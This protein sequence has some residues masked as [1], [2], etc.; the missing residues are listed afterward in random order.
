[1]EDKEIFP[2]WGDLDNGEESYWSADWIIDPDQDK[3]KVVLTMTIDGSETVN[4]FYPE[5][6]EAF[7]SDTL[8]EFVARY[9]KEEVT[10]ENIK[11]LKDFLFHWL[12]IVDSDGSME[13]GIDD[14]DILEQDDGF[15]EN[16][17]LH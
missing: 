3:N 9:Y 12:Q 11:E 13:F 5:V 6:R 8:K 7:Q 17:T 14:D 1:M 15:T 4:W 10:D 16:N 2:S